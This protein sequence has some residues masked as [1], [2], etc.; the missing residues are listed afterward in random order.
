MPEGDISRDRSPRSGSKRTT[1]RATAS[2]TSRHSD[3]GTAATPAPGPSELTR[4][5]TPDYD[6]TVTALG[7]PFAEDAEDEK[8]ATE[9][10]G[11]VSAAVEWV[12]SVTFQG[13]P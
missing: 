2:A 4:L 13:M 9:L 3:A 6:L 8:I 10:T 1:G 11:Q 12:G 5:D 7:D